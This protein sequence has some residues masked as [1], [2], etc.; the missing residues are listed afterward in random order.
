MRL[1]TALV[2]PDDVREHLDDFLD[3]RR[4]AG[5]FRWSPAET[6]HVTLAFAADV[7]E[8]RVD[9][10]LERTAA[11]AQRRTPFEARVASGGTFPAVD[12]ARVLWAGL[13][14]DG[15]GAEQLDLLAAGARTAASTAGAEVDG[16][17]FRPHVTVA[18]SGL[19][20]PMGDWV[21]LLD[22]YVGPT[23]TADEV[24]VVASHLGE[25]PRRRPRHEVLATAPIGA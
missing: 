2:L 8:W 24:A 10:V 18:R 16:G 6:F 9:E 11:A 13:A 7:D 12:A 5:D 19:P 3:V 22:T 4:A 17:R 25:G 20:V 1:F 23:W 15:H 21:K 14:L